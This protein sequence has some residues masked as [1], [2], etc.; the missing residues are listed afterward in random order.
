[1]DF[2]IGIKKLLLVIEMSAQLTSDGT[3]TASNFFQCL[4]DYGM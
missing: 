3:V 1:M 2:G 4:A